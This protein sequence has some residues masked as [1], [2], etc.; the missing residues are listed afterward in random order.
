MNLYFRLLPLLSQLAAIA[1]QE[2]NGLPKGDV[3]LYYLC[4]EFCKRLE[5][6]N[7][8]IAQAAGYSGEIRNFY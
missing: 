3:G 7:P 6:R 4:R 1:A 2:P 5:T 8:G